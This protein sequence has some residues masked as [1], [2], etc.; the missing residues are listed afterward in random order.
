MNDLPRYDTWKLASPPEAPACTNCHHD[1]S[2]HGPWIVEGTDRLEDDS[3]TVEG[4]RCEMYDDELPERD[5][6]EAYDRRFD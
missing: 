6:D 2:E 3:C 5:P 1:Y 4:C